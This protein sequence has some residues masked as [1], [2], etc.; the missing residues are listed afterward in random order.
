R[1]HAHTHTHTRARTHTH[2][3]L[4]ARTFPHTNAPH[5][6]A[7]VMSDSWNHKYAREQAA[8]P[9]QWVRARKFWPPVARVDNAYG[10]RNLVCECPPMT[11]Y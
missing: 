8:Y 5:T 3:F 2:T 11:E 1:T 10:D 4:Y 9:A 7:M 6:H